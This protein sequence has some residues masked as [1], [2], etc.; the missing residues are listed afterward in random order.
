MVSR[1]AV[2]CHWAL[3]NAQRLRFLYSLIQLNLGSFAESFFE[4]HL[5]PRGVSLAAASS[6][7][8]ANPLSGSL[9]SRAYRPAARPCKVTGRS[10]AL[11]TLPWSPPDA[12]PVSEV[13]LFPAV[14]P[15]GALSCCLCVSVP[16]AS[17]TLSTFHAWFFRIFIIVTW[18]SLPAHFSSEAISGFSHPLL[19][20]DQIFLPFRTSVFFFYYISD[21]LHQITV[22]PLLSGYRSWSTES[23]S[24]VIELSLGFFFFF[25]CSLLCLLCYILYF[26]KCRISFLITLLLQEPIFYFRP[27]LYFVNCRYFV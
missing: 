22:F 17:D 23:I 18:K 14:C 12:A 5:W 10:H 7:K 25:F 21:I 13:A 19:I 15:L 16:V 1:H 24:S 27:M 20:I 3:S 2:R 6:D 11:P 4:A 26:M 8:A 9:L